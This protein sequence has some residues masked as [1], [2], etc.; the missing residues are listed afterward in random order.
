MLFVQQNLNELD[1]TTLI[2]ITW[3]FIVIMPVIDPVYHKHAQIAPT[4]P[5]KNITTSG[6]YEALEESQRRSLS[7]SSVIKT[8][9]KDF[10][11]SKCPI[12]IGNMR[13]KRPAHTYLSRKETE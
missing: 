6:N 8:E 7:Q 13:V 3:T 9:G 2:T 12:S 10:G 1:Q 4:H 11:L 5:N